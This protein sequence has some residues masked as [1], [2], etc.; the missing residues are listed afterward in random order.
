MKYAR[1]SKERANDDSDVVQELRAQVAEQQRL[2]R[3]ILEREGSAATNGSGGIMGGNVELTPL[4]TKPPSQVPP[5]K[6]PVVTP[7]HS[8]SASSHAANS[9]SNPQA[10]RFAIPPHTGGGGG[11]GGTLLAQSPKG[12]AAG[13]VLLAS[14]TVGGG[15][16]GSL[17]AAPYS[18]ADS[19]R[20]SPVPIAQQKQQQHVVDAPR[21]VKFPL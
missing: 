5:R 11:G 19:I 18:A 10:D 9:G 16:Y 6:S 3:Q 21:K 14:Q 13:S 8:S 2:I 20:V 7:R 4:L 15:A 12:M 17:G 1:K